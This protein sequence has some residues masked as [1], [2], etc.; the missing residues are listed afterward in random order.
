MYS[1]SCVSVQPES[2]PVIEEEIFGL[3]VF[4]VQ[5]GVFT[6]KDDLIPQHHLVQRLTHTVS[7]EQ[8]TVNETAHFHLFMDAPII[9]PIHFR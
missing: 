6:S 1:E 9:S 4:E 5:F 8:Q 3:H 2:V 7:I